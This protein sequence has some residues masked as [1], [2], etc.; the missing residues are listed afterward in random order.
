[1]YQLSFIVIATLVLVYSSSF[2]APFEISPTADTK[3]QQDIN[4][5][6]EDTDLSQFSITPAPP[7]PKAKKT[8]KPVYV[9]YK[10]AMSPRFGAVIGNAEEENNSD[11]Q[12][13]DFG[14]LLGFNYYYDTITQGKFETG[15]D[16]Y[17]DGIGV[18]NFSKKWVYSPTAKLSPHIKVGVDLILRPKNG[19][20]TIL[21][22]DNYLLFGSLGIE[23][24]LYDP[25]SLRF[26]IEAAVGIKDYSIR[27]VFGYT[28]GW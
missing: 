12:A 7:V 15:L 27:L 4:N 22:I 19:F 17:S 14:Y 21:D 8:E 3:S 5:H 6:Q 13:F 16:L 26:D 28:W 11:A 18:F 1:M 2:S 23:D 25:M 10:S 9:Y 24:F 20:A